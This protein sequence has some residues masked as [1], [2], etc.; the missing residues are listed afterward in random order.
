ML[1]GFKLSNER[2]VLSADFTNSAPLEFDSKIAG[3][4]SGFR[5]LSDPL[6]QR[7]LFKSSAIAAASTV[8][9]VGGTIDTT[10]LKNP[11]RGGSLRDDYLL[12]GISA[13]EQVEV[14]LNST[15]F[16]AY[17]QVVDASTGTA[18][19][20]N[21][22]FNG[23][24]SQLTFTAAQ[25]I[26][27]I[28]RATTYK[29]D[30]TGSYTLSSNLGVL[31]PASPI[32][33]NQSFNGAIANSDPSN[34]IREGSFY[35]GYVLSNLVAGQQVQ[36]NLDSPSF[37]TYL[38]VVNAGTGAIVA[39]NNDFSGTNSQLSFTVAEGIDY[40]LQATTFEK[41]ATGGY[42]LTTKIASIPDPLDPGNTLGTAKAQTS[43]V[44]SNNQQV[45]ASD[46]DDFYSFNVAE[47]GIFTANLSALSGDADVRLIQD[48]NNNGVIDQGEV[49][50]WQWERGTGNESI[51]RF[52]SA[53]NYFLQVMSYNNQTANYSVATT[54]TAATSD[55]LSFSIKVNFGQGLG[56]L[57]T[58]A[59]N[60]ITEA[61]KVWE[62]I[63]PYST[64]TN[65]QV[66]TIDVTGDTFGKDEFLA[67]AGPKTFASDAL[68]NQMTI[69]GASTINTSL[70]NTYNSDPS[71]LKETMV[72]EFGHVL[73]IGTLWSDFGRDLINF[74]D[75]TYSANTYAGWAYGELKGTFLQTVVPVQKGVFGHWDEDVFDNELMSPVAEANFELLSQLTIASLKDIGWNVNYGGAE[76]Y[77]LPGFNAPSNS[78]N[79][80]ASLIN[81]SFPLRCG[82]AAHLASSS[83][84]TLGSSS[85]AE[86][87]FGKVA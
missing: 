40:I 18:V 57:S 9:E 48:S 73:G 22:D 42:T 44:F 68:G 62:K 4:W 43:A 74:S 30:A 12:T 82:C 33:G 76:P 7:S 15:E 11:I 29:P 56:S 20:F 14:K 83:L 53:G 24:N 85:L 2:Q 46:R 86:H 27:Y 69:S 26:D 75:A 87:I 49:L 1:N 5:G 37:N 64:F 32:S 80:N 23:L 10:D 6:Q 21:D 38:Q 60:A 72:H 77:S 59:L 25:G 28:V 3:I 47:S 81:S 70:A 54:F 79:A 61:A 16:D 71:F 63:I 8:S 31:K 78:L 84:A 55:P 67:F 41:G 39:E 19:A 50:G 52:L 66:L 65:S 58:E 45:N 35:D 34:P 17:L 36:V 51:R 13:G